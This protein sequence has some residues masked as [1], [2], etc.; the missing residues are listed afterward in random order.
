MIIS[1]HQPNYLPYLGFFDKIIKSDIFVVYDDAQFNKKDYHH[2]NKIR[3]HDGWKWLTVP[4]VNEEKPI[5]EITIKNEQ[6]Q[7]KAHWARV[8]FKEIQA[9]YSKTEYFSTYEKELKEIYESRYDRLVDLNI[10]IIKFLMKAFDIHKK[11]VYSSEFGF[12]SKSSQK[13]LDIVDALGGDVYLS[14]SG[15]CNY[16]DTSLFSAKGIRV[17]YQDFKHPL[18]KQRFESF[19]PNMASI[20]ALFNIG[21]MPEIRS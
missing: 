20:D 6:E 17:E 13:N 5:N 2:R 1:I 16:L 3:I 12:K 7:N 18:Y 11:I 15:G 8:H 10:S 21:K 19:V 4:V 14:G 9:N